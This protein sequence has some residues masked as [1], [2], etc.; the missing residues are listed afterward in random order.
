MPV[1]LNQSSW[2]Q[3]GRSKEVRWED[4]M[5]LQDRYQSTKSLKKEALTELNSTK[6]IDKNTSP[7]IKP[8]S[9]KKRQLSEDACSSWQTHSNRMNIENND[10]AL[11]NRRLK[12]NSSIQMIVIHVIDTNTG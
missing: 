9:A 6:E 2:I 10:S 4:I 3:G 11:H 1:F 12:S 7:T 5:Q 8:D